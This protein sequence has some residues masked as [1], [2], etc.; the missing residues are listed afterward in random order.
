MGVIMKI[1]NPEKVEKITKS[2]CV[3]IIILTVLVITF[4]NVI[5]D[6]YSDFSNYVLESIPWIRWIVL[7]LIILFIISMATLSML[8]PHESNYSHSSVSGSQSS[9]PVGNPSP[10]REGYWEE[11]SRNQQYLPPINVPGGLINVTSNQGFSQ[12]PR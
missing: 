10:T 7:I 11:V 9:N 1:S 3:A 12:E 2:I 8:M 4:G 5:A 6:R